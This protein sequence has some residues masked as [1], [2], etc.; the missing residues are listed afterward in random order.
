MRKAHGATL[1][2]PVAGKRK[3]EAT[4]GFHNHLMM[5]TLYDC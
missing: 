2:T 3:S 4:F 1:F 5:E